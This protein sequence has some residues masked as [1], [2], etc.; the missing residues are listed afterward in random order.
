VLSGS[1]DQIPP[2][3]FLIIMLSRPQDVPYREPG[4]I[5]RYLPLGQEVTLTRSG[6]ADVQLPQAAG[7]P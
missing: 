3:K 5:E 1:F 4:A 7:E 2:G 6:Q